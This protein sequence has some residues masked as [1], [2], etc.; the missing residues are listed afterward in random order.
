[1]PYTYNCKADPW[2]VPANDLFL[3]GRRTVAYECLY[4]YSL[5]G[6]L[7]LGHYLIALPW[8]VSFKVN[9]FIMLEAGAALLLGLF[10][11]WLQFRGKVPRDF[12]D[13]Q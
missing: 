12:R 3:R 4:L 13:M 8:K 10:T 11:A 7:V 9:L 1:M 2:P 5:I 6:M